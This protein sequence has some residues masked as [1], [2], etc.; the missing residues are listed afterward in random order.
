MIY[1][2]MGLQNNE[3]EIR[4]SRDTHEEAANCI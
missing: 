3:D 1:I 2:Y 4:G